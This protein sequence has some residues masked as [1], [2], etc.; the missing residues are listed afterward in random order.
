MEMQVWVPV[1]ALRINCTYSLSSR[2]RS[3]DLLDLHGMA[4]N[5]TGHAELVTKVAVALGFASFDRLQSPH[6]T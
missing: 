6:G 1:R 3:L 2:A 4:G 5:L